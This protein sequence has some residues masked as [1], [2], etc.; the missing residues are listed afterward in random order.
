M[1][2]RHRLAEQQRSVLLD[3]VLAG[4]RVILAGGVEKTGANLTEKVREA[5]EDALQRLYPRFV[6]ADDPRWGKV[7]ERARNGAADA[8]EAVGYSGDPEKHRVCQAIL[9]FVAG[10]KKGREIRK[11]FVAPP[12]G[13]PQD[14]IDGAL[15]VLTGSSHL[16]AAQD[17]KV[18]TQKQ[19]DQRNL[20][21]A[22]FRLESAT[23]TV[24][25][26]LALRKLF[27]EAGV[28][29]PPNE[30]ANAARSFL[31]VMKTLASTAGGEAP[32]PASPNPPL[33]GELSSLAGNEQL[34]AIHEA[35][36]QLSGWRADWS[37]RADLISK[38]LPRWQ[39]LGKL[40]AHARAL[41]VAAETTP[42]IEALRTNR[43]LLNEPDPVVPLVGTL[44]QALR[45]ALQ[46][47]REKYSA[48][49]QQEM[50]R[51]AA[52]DTW[53]RLTPEQQAEVLN[54]YGVAGVPDIRVGTEQELLTSLA[55]I[56]LDSW[57]T[58]HDALPQRFANALE[59]AAKLIEP[60]AVRVSLPS[61]TIRN[62]DELRAWLDDVEAR[63]RGQLGRG[64]V[65]V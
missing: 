39:A 44:T 59:E 41:P 31:E 61:A 56:S 17:G 57:M 16:R 38:R 64:P 12:Y 20:G 63:L 11:Q 62:D 65:I 45:E 27:Q 25:Q 3:E 60:K 24:Q 53:Q 23:V 9:A 55:E 50:G 47:A 30:E 21:V 6:D 13:W 36:E 26:R 49:Y 43:A 8:L 15:I 32:L 4:A 35:R 18:L 52:A 34:V 10:G 40:I 19:L 22:D 51:L 2:T 1:E 46:Q 28:Q 54:R 58:R 7:V 42:Q 48:L 29:T 5:A 33:L 37:K 14:A